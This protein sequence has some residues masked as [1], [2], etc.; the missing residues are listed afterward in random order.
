MKRTKKIE[1]NMES[2][3]GIEKSVMEMVDQDPYQIVTINTNR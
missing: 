1:L 2:E 3:F